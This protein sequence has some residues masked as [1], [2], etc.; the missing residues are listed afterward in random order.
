MERAQQKA[1]ELAEQ[2]LAEARALC[3]EAAVAM[4]ENFR[5]KELEAKYRRAVIHVETLERLVRAIE[6]EFEM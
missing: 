5:S 2:A 1:L 3:G 6:E 4:E